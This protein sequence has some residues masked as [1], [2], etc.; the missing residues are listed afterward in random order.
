MGIR[1]LCNVIFLSLHNILNG[2]GTIIRT[3]MSNENNVNHPEGKS[4][5]NSTPAACWMVWNFQGLIMRI[6]WLRA[7]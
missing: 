3:K 6:F 7:K 4:H 5:E 2:L 1:I